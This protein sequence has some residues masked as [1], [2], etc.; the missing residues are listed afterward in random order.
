ME[1]QQEGSPFLDGSK[2]W[3]GRSR[4]GPPSDTLLSNPVLCPETRGM[5]QAFLFA[6]I[7]AVEQALQLRRS[8]C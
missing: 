6:D 2:S 7:V 4:R 1:P 3:F 8:V 5:R